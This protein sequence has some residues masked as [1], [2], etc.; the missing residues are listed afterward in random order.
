MYPVT[1]FLPHLTSVE[2]YLMERF[3]DGISMPEELAQQISE[4]ESVVDVF[5]SRSDGIRRGHRGLD[6]GENSYSTLRISSKF[7]KSRLCHHIPSVRDPHHSP[8]ACME[9][10]QGFR[11]IPFYVPIRYWGSSGSHQVDPVREDAERRAHASLCVA[12]MCGLPRLAARLLARGSLEGRPYTWQH[13]R[14]WPSSIVSPSYTALHYITCDNGD[15]DISNFLYHPQWL[16]AELIFGAGFPLEVAV[17]RSF[18]AAEG[19]QYSGVAVSRGSVAEAALLSGTSSAIVVLLEQMRKTPASQSTQSEAALVDGLV[20]RHSMACVEVLVHNMLCSKPAFSGQRWRIMEMK[21]EMDRLQ[22]P[23]QFAIERLDARRPPAMVLS[24]L[25]LSMCRAPVLAFQHM[26]RMPEVVAA[27]ALEPA[28]HFREMLFIGVDKA[29]HP[30][31]SVC[32]QPL[33]E[34]GGSV[35]ACGM[36]ALHWLAFLPYASAHSIVGISAVC[37]LLKAGAHIDARAEPRRLYRAAPGHG[38]RILQP[39]AV[40]APMQG[41]PRAGRQCRPQRAALRRTGC[42]AQGGDGCGLEG[43]LAGCD[44]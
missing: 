13:D 23:I 16:T 26:W 6:R 8:L 7:A 21:T 38:H 24:M 18:I 14:P 43:K 15:L 11:H 19:K 29:L 27:L 25:L 20:A 17:G 33:L 37:E 35:D 39:C 5:F 1:F 3:R 22:T 34:A 44:P 12:V 30:L 28:Y 9:G 40:P 36:T 4:L 42:D 31:E 10:W 32:V 2:Y 41:E